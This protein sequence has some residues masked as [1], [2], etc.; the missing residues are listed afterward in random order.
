LPTSGIAKAIW[1]VRRERS[2]RAAAFGTYPTASAARVTRAAVSGLVRIPLRTREA[3]A[4]DTFARRATVVIVGTSSCV[5]SAVSTAPS[6]SVVL[7]RI[8]ENVYKRVTMP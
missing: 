5:S 3:D 1:P 6:D 2:E 4:I 7:K 8:T